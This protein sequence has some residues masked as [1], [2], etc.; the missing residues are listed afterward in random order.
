[1]K[2]LS[3]PLNIPKGKYQ[4]FPLCSEK[5]GRRHA[6]LQG[7]KTNICCKKNLEIVDGIN[8]Y[9]ISN[10]GGYDQQCNKLNKKTLK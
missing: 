9:Y 7:A 2:T 10:F 1:M 5:G 8:N 6:S 4:V 3:G